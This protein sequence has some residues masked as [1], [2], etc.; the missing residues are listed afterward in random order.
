MGI[1]NLPRFFAVQCLGIWW[2]QY[3]GSY[4]GQVS[5][6]ALVTGPLPGLPPGP[7]SMPR[8]VARSEPEDFNFTPK[9]SVYSEKLHLSEGAASFDGCAYQCAQPHLSSLDQ[10]LC[11]SSHLVTGTSIMLSPSRT[12]N[13]IPLH[14]GAPFSGLGS[15]STMGITNLPR[16]FAVQCLG[17]CWLQSLGAYGRQ[18]SG[19]ALVT[20]PLPGVPP[21]TWSMPRC[22]AHS[23]PEDFNFTPNRSVYSEKL[24][25]SE[26]AA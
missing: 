20:S 23:E 25:L 14:I 21:G 4:G 15:T 1:T 18:V 13:I 16:F 10:R 17:I 8:C 5:G 22:V 24:R 12:A 19:P 7:W 11:L 26:G 6:P 9:R 2:L 3:L